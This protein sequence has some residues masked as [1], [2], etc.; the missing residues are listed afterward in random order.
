M[1][2]C[3]VLDG[4]N[5]TEI[6]VTDKDHVEKAGKENQSATTIIDMS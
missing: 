3:G 5:K 1:F 2:L 6:R 4:T